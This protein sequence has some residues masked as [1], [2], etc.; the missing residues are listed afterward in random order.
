M[1]LKPLN[2]GM[3]ILTPFAGLGT[4]HHDQHRKRRAA[5]SPYF[6][7]AAVVAAEP[8]IHSYM[9]LLGRK[10]EKAMAANSAVELR[11]LYLAIASDAF[12][13]HAFKKPLGYANNEQAAEDWRRTVDS[14]AAMTPLAKQIY[15]VYPLAMKLPQKWIK[16]L[17]PDMAQ[18][19][20]LRSVN[21]HSLLHKLTANQDVVS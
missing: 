10:L 4:I 14:T 16:R 2:G 8:T 21:D 13:T 17:S 9:D 19:L 5:Y 12:F 20:T 18:I 3:D 11:T 1:L 6:S 15:W 7:K